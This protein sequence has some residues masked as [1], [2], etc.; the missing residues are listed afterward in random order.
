MIRTALIAVLLNA[1]CLT[2]ALLIGAS[3]D[4]KP[5]ALYRDPAAVVEAKFA[6]GW[7][8]N[9]GAV[10]MFATATVCLFA[11][12]ILR[13]TEP[14]PAFGVL[15]LMLATDDLFMI[16]DG[17]FPFVGLPGTILYGLYAGGAVVWIARFPDE[18]LRTRWPIFVTALAFLGM[19]AVA[20]VVVDHVGLHGEVAYLV[21]DTSKL[22]GIVFWTSYGLSFAWSAVN[23]HIDARTV[24]VAGRNV[25][26]GRDIRT[27]EA[28]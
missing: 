11:A 28:A 12:C 26:Q 19:S 20:D 23:R 25:A 3:Y 9:L 1:V 10:L 22:M 5:S 7:F 4:I 16:H 18:I 21:E 2:V 27:L 17:V 24:A 15:T 13:W 14:L 8:S 6:I